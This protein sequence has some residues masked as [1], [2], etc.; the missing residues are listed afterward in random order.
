ME[1]TLPRIY[2]TSDSP[3]EGD[4]LERTKPA[5]ALR[6]L[7]EAFSEGCV[8]GLN[9]K[10]GSGKTTFLCMWERYMENLEYKVIHFNSWENDNVEDPL[11]ALVAEF[12]KLTNSKDSTWTTFASNFGKISFAMLPAILGALAEQLTGIPVDKITEKAGDKGTEIM[13]KAIDSYIEQK[14]SISEFKIALEK[15]VEENSNGK[16]VI[17]VID[18]LDRCNPRFAVK[19][20]E[21]IKHLFEIENVVYLLAVDEIQLANSIK[22]YYGS[23]QFDAKDYLRR[24]IRISY[25]LPSSNTVNVVNALFER[26]EFVKLFKRGGMYNDEYKALAEFIPILYWERKMSIRQLEQY[27]LSLRIVLGNMLRLRFHPTTI[28]LMMLLKMF[29]SELFEKYLT[30]EVDDNNFIKYIEEHFDD[31]LF[32]GKSIAS[33]YCFYQ[34]VADMMLI[35]Y[36]Q[37]QRNTS[38]CDKNGNLKFHTSRFDLEQFPVCFSNVDP[39]MPGLDVVRARFEVLS[40]INL[41]L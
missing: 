20:L 29:D 9:G 3:F 8:M 27:M 32:D 5:A 13:S 16:P 31:V 23:E 38:L 14:K 34:G 17:F 40:S 2:P 11:I 36:K 18:E 35:R 10:W 41:N 1:T 15:Y 22:G 39:M 7:V 33:L 25:D 24:F 28:A 19:T 26:F 37:D 12:Q 6:T 4:L 21:R 30:Y